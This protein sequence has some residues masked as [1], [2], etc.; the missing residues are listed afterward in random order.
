MTVIELRKV[1]REHGVTLSAGISKQGIVDRLTDALV[2]ASAPAPVEAP[3]SA[4]APAAPV[5]R[6]AAIV[7]DDDDTPVLTPNAPFNRAP[8][9]PAPTAPRQ[10]MARPAVSAPPAGQPTV[11]RGNVPGTNKP[12]FSLEGVRAWHNPRSYQQQPQQNAYQQRPQQNSY[13][14]QSY[15]QQRPMQRTAPTVSRFG[16]AAASDTPANNYPANEP[17]R[18]EALE[19]RPQP[20][21]QQSYQSDYRSRPAVPAPAPV[22][23]TALPDLLATG[24]IENGSGILDIQSEGHGYLRTGNYLPGREDI[25]VSTAQV[26]RF[27]LRSGDLVTGKVRSRREGETHAMLL[28]ITEIN[29]VDAQD[30]KAI[31]DFDTLTAVYPM[32][33]LALSQE[34]DHKLLRAADLVSPIGLGQRLLVNVPGCCDKAELLKTL[35]SALKAAAPKAQIMSL[36]L[37]Q[38]PEDITLAREDLPGEVAYTAFDAAEESTVKVAELSLSH[39]RRL[40]E[41]KKD[42]I[43]L[44]DC[45]SALPADL[46]KKLFGAARALREGGSLTVIALCENCECVLKRYANAQWTLAD[47]EKL[48]PAA[49]FTVRAEAMLAD[50]E[51]TQLSALRALTA[52]RLYALIESTESNVEVIAQL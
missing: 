45:L 22:S 40:A 7:A 29:G 8:S 46:A 10:N 41:R 20:A 27:H 30:V 2:K 44:I 6:A 4:P 39:A 17:Y 16:P 26:R 9:A 5:R 36:L 35:G 21:Y 31:P 32:Q 50:A 25:Y 15:G 11:N 18:S 1:A 37:A 23:A 52:D 28:Y 38:R 34:N 13:G 12:V 24:D 42:V 14:Q 47:G 51:K 49:S 48:D 19:T 33:K 3:A 43:V